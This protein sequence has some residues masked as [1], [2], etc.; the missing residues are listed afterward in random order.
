M[1]DPTYLRE[2]SYTADKVEAQKR[3]INRKIDLFNNQSAGMQEI[4]EQLH[5]LKDT[6]ERQQTLR[7][8]KED[9]VEHREE[10]DAHFKDDLCFTVLNA[11]D[12]SKLIPTVPKLYFHG[13][14]LHVA[15]HILADGKISSPE[16]RGLFTYAGDRV[17]AAGAHKLNTAIMHAGRSVAHPFGC[18]FAILPKSMEGK[19]YEPLTDE[20]G[21]VDFKADPDQLYAII[22]T[23]ENIET[24]K[25][26]ATK[27]GSD[28][29]K[30]HTYDTFIQTLQQNIQGI[31][32]EK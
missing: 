31:T 6:L 21:D 12:N 24:V 15:K 5:M 29:N 26:W 3:V 20:I 19:E 27:G 10:M 8:P 30:V 2:V 11:Y 25:Q 9:D 1:N 23:P 18:I 16:S 13:T 7:P 22:T 17:F 32:N 14:E 28:P 4:N